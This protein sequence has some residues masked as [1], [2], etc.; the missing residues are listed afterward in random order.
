MIPVE[1]PASGAAPGL[2]HEPEG[3]PNKYADEITYIEENRDHKKPSFVDKTSIVQGSNRCDQQA[4]KYKYFIH[5]FG[6]PGNVAFECFI[7]ELFPNGAKT[8]GKQLLRT[9]GDF[10][11]NGNDL[12]NHIHDP[13]KPQ[14]M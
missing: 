6:G 5:C 1:Y 2:H 13:N 11:L 9:Q 3:A 7:I 10:V 12:Q 14:Q 8:I 4:P